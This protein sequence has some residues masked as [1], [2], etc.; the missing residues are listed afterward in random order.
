MLEKKERMTVHDIC[1]SGFGKLLLNVYMI[2]NAMGLVI[3]HLY[4]KQPY[5]PKLKLHIAIM[6][7]VE[8]VSWI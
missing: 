7:A 1:I 4:D 2:E 6:F 3:L 8:Y 5:L